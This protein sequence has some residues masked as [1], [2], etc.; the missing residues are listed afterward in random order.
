MRN[1]SHE[2]GLH[3]S[4]YNNKQNPLAYLFLLLKPPSFSFLLFPF[5]PRTEKFMPQPS[6]IVL[7]IQL[8]FLGA[9][10]FINACMSLSRKICDA[11]NSV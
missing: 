10:F 8:C 5:P 3:F 9:L 4:Q 11:P 2:V 7:T 1:P 6:A